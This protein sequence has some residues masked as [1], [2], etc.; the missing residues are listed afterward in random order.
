M[1]DDHDWTKVGEHQAEA[2]T[3][4]IMSGYVFGYYCEYICDKCLLMR[5]QC[6]NESLFL[7][8]YSTDRLTLESV[9]CKDAKLKYLLL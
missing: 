7:Y 4:F 1:T 6:G 5:L 8:G 2:Q 9:S 3:V